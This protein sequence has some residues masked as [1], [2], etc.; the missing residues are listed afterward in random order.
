M[1]K[2]TITICSSASF[3]R[4]VLAIQETL[5]KLGYSVL[6]PDT[7]VLMKKND[8]FDI[9]HY[10]T[11]YSNEKDYKK[12]TMLMRNHFKKVLKADIILVVNEE[13]NGRKGYIGGNVL[14][15]MTLAFHFKKPIYILNPVDT[16]S[17]FLEEILGLHP[18]M[19]DGSTK[20]LA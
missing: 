11:W 19:L 20:K 7:A 13:K 12:K 3:Y 2:K 10:K 1:K 15:E 14:M 8:D 18:I 9:S 17:Q 16:T 4:K 5:S 6:V